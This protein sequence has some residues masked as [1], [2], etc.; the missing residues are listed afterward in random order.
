MTLFEQILSLFIVWNPPE[1]PYN[2]AY[3]ESWNREY[4]ED[5]ASQLGE[6]DVAKRGKGR[7]VNVV[8]IA[9]CDYTFSEDIEGRLTLGSINEQ[10]GP[11]GSPYSVDELKRDI[12]TIHKKG[13][14]V[15]L[16]FGGPAFPMGMVIR[17]ERDADD[18]VQKMAKAVEQFGFDGIDFVVE[19]GLIPAQ[20]QTYLYKSCRAKLGGK[21]FIS[22]TIPALAEYKEPYK[23][24]LRAAARCFDSINV[25]AYDLYWDGYDFAQDLDGLL[26]L[27]VK[28]S[29]IVWGIMPGQQEDPD[30]FTGVEE[31]QKIA[32]YV[33]DSG[34]R[35]VTIW[36][37]NRDT[38]HRTGSD[39]ASTFYQTGE[40]DGTFMNAI[41][42]VYVG[43]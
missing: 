5:Y 30:A 43:G 39:G 4:Y 11:S 8:N 25:M 24:T 28:K 37:L 23:S 26:S 34:L 41:N 15:K 1:L 13:G 33:K 29:Q 40:A 17:S 31:V 14:I 42:A 32:Q 12:A 21:K 2:E 10:V 38:D 35:G 6:L 27:G 18:F 22:L 9:F 16:S 19:N 20:L 7:G 3:W 36:S